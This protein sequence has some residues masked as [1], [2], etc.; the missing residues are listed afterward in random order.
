LTIKQL[1][2]DGNVGGAAIS[3][4][5]KYF[6]YTENGK[7]SFWF[8]HVNGGNPVQLRSPEGVR[9][10]QL[11]FARDGTSILYQLNGG[12]F[13]IPV[14]G[15]APQKL[16]GRIP[17]SYALSYDGKSVAFVRG[18]GDRKV[19]AIIIANLDGS[20]E[21]ELVTLP[22]GAGF[23]SY[24]PAWSPDGRMLAIG[25]ASQTNP[26]QQVLI[27]VQVADG[28]M[29][30]LNPQAWDQIS[31]VAWTGDGNGIVFHGRG[32][33]S[34]YHIWLLDYP[35]GELR[36]ITPDPSHY[37]RDSVSLSDNANSL[38]A[39]RTEENCSLWVGPADDIKQSRQITG[40]SFGKQDGDYGL[41][42]TPDGKIVY[43]SS[44]NNSY[45]LWV[46]NQ[47][48]SGASQIT[49]SGFTDLSPRVTA[50]GRYIVFQ[51]NRGGSTEIWRVNPDGSDM[52]RLTSGGNN[53]NPE[54]TPDGKWVLYGSIIGGSGTMW[55]VSIDGGEPERVIPD[56][57]ADCPKVSPDGKLLACAY[58]DRAVSP[59][60]Q[61]AV[62][63]LN[64]FRLVYHF[65]LA[66]FATFNN[67][68]H[69]TADGS[70][71][72]YRNFVG[73]VW[74]QPLTGGAAEK[75]RGAPDKRILYYDWSRD[76]K[77]FAMAYGD[78]IRD[79]VLISNFR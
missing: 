9:Y 5:G 29:R 77:Q 45:S 68:L 46:I 33:E 37:G 39:V 61:L 69:W 67:G 2:A 65:D 66:R 71:V 3:P 22:V 17:P 79:V 1:T 53:T 27:S 10:G 26:N 49:P 43:T 35:G 19:S 74:R 6:V 23:S 25:A 13:E 28:K 62:L 20:G 57:P 73:G 7:E 48:G 50:H 47:D 44:F 36:C 12:L 56:I 38:V 30:Q 4:D 24:G 18:D 15:G 70:A 11:H 42:W 59:R 63:S 58:Y 75:L 51:S 54:P 52:R 34:Y 40:G 72:T 78:E 60:Q 32:P 31:T 8:G 64:D 21:R 16:L 14:L 76:G 55:R 41:E